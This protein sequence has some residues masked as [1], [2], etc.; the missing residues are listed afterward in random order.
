LG[1]RPDRA[2]SQPHRTA[3]RTSAEPVIEVTHQLNEGGIDIA[4]AA[5]D[6]PR[7]ENDIAVNR[8]AWLW[9]IPWLHQDG[10]ERAPSIGVHNTAVGDLSVDWIASCPR[11]QDRVG[12]SFC[13][14]SLGLQKKLNRVLVQAHIIIQP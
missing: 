1:A 14:L 8:V 4:D 2:R 13:Q 3:G 6:L 11:N 9:L 7:H 5:G 12:G 10:P